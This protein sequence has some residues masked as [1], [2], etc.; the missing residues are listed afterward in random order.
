M[1]Y[2]SEIEIGELPVRIAMTDPSSQPTTA[3]V[4]AVRAKRSWLPAMLSPTTAKPIAMKPTIIGANHSARMPS[5]QA[6]PLSCA[7]A[8]AVPDSSAS[9]SRR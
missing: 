3:I 1:L 9:G 8:E 4:R 5:P 6:N 2:D 7:E